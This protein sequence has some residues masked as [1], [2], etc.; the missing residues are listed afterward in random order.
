MYTICP[1][2]RLLHLLLRQVLWNTLIGAVSLGGKNNQQVQTAIAKQVKRYQKL[3]EAFSGSA[4]LEAAL[5]VHIQVTAE[6]FQAVS[7][8]VLHPNCQGAHQVP[9]PM[10]HA[11][12]VVASSL[13][14]AANNKYSVINCA[15]QEP[16]GQS[17][18]VLLVHRC[19][20]TR[21]RS[22]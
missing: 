14:V 9:A 18:N 4:R 6:G 7:T 22:C 3:L 13:I 2:L 11:R 19:I 20:A 10:R 8:K 21:T 17:F 5:M 15:R 12:L 1:P 16:R